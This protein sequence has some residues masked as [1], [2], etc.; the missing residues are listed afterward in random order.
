M[1]G[2]HFTSP[3]LC[4]RVYLRG[5]CCACAQSRLTLCNPMD[6]SPAGSSVHGGSPSMNTGVSCHALPPGDLSDP[7]ITS[8]SFVTPALT[9]GFFSTSTT[10]FCF[11]E[12]LH[13]WNSYYSL[14]EKK[15][16]VRKTYRSAIIG[17][18]MQDAKGLGV[19][20]ERWKRVAFQRKDRQVEVTGWAQR[21]EEREEKDDR[22]IVYG[23][24]TTHR[25][26]AKCCAYIISCV[27]YESL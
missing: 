17:V 4:L 12:V 14:G 15:M 25:P 21:L 20:W 24:L 5:R 6:S 1:L 27:P 19:K 18:Q 26:S 16:K 10:F 7:G 9:G 11:C 13:K 3:S 8:I 23:A 22:S 2:N